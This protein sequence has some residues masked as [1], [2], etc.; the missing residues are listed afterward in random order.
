M[1]QI[2]MAWGPHRYLSLMTR[3]A[4]DQLDLKPGDSATAV[5][6]ATTVIVERA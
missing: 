6:K 2:D 4:P 5:I 3:E 1:A